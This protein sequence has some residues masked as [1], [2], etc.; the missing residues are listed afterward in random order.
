M[1]LKHLN[2]D[3]TTSRSLIGAD[4]LANSNQADAVKDFTRFQILNNKVLKILNPLILEYS[5]SNIDELAKLEAYNNEIM[6]EID[7][8]TN[9]YNNQ[10]SRISNFNYDINLFPNYQQTFKA[11]LTGLQSAIGDLR[12][13]LELNN[14]NAQLVISDNILNGS[15]KDL[16]SKYIIQKNTEGLPFDA[17]QILDIDLDIKPWYAEYLTKYGA[18]SN[19]IFD[20]EK[21]S[22]IVA[23]L[24]DNGVITIDEF[25]SDRLN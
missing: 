10:I 20:T 7:R 13:N 24:I 18:P 19:G 9:F 25:I 4:N 21:L 3:I 8:K 11:V 1:G 16:I 5:K 23:E 14:I 22:L 15:N 17:D 12:T 6:I 2:G